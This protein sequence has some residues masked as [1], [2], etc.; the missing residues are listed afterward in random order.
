VTRAMGSAYMEWAKLHSGARFNLASSGVVEYPLADLPVRL[1][2]LVLSGPGAYGWPPLL[3]RL[4]AKCGVS[5]DNVVAAMGTSM[6]NHLALA[7]L[8]GPGDEVLIERPAYDPMVSVARYLGAEVRRFDRR[9]E[10]GFAVRPDEVAR[11][12][13]PRT[14]AIVLTNLHN[15]SSALIDTATLRQV[16]AIARDVGARVLVDEVYLDS[17]FERTPPSSFHL[18]P[19]CFVVTS[20]LTKAYGLSG[21]RCGWVLADPDLARRIWRIDDL[22]A[23]NPPHVAEQLSAIALDHL[24]AIAARAKSLL[25]EN[26]GIVNEFLQSR[27]DLDWDRLDYGMTTF[28]RLKRGSVDDLCQRLRERYETTVVPGRFFEMPDHFRVAVGCSTEMLR[29]GLARLAA[30][31]DQLGADVT[32]R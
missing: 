13:T 1:D 17:L 10:D 3:R 25:E 6:A 9:A 12:I 22:F 29:E 4:A 32:P 15:P 2:D 11:A 18:D 14:K 20:S 30:A 31:L 8:A 5:P 16:G 7:A 28:P 24:P 26:R 27:T 19:G 21:L 23:A